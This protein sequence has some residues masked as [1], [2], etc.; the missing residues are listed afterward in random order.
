[1]RMT[2]K[3]SKL[4]GRL[5][6]DWSYS[7]NDTVYL[8]VTSQVTEVVHRGGRSLVEMR[9]YTPNAVCRFRAST[10]STKE[11]ETLEWIDQFG[12]EGAFFDVGANIGLYSV[13]Y[14]KT[15]S[16]KVYAFEPSVLNLGL[17]AKNLKENGISDRVIIIPNPLTARNQISDL[18]MSS[19]DEGG[20][21]S[22][23]G[24]Q[25]G[26]DGQPIQ[27][28]MHFQTTGYSLDFL[29][30]MGIVN[31]IPTLMKID[32]DGIEHLVLQGAV[33]LL[34][35]QTL[36]TILIEVNDN[37]VDL[38]IGVRD[39]LTAA[40]FVLTEKRQAKMFQEGLFSH[41]FNQIWVR[42]N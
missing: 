26:Q 42:L 32:V 19:L 31:E 34:E 6:A 12:S 28:Q 17:L 5:S 27:E 39:S 40:G 4:L 11:P 25:F 33:N 14:A 30:E 15:Q 3:Y 35:N 29:I 8:A 1:M 22:T 10:F 16:G 20:A 37:F 13:Y 18:H 2:S 21:L 24:E 36:R 7:W 41:S 38:A 9:F 23:F